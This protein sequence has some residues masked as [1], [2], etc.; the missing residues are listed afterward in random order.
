MLC[1]W[2]CCVLRGVTSH[3]MAPARLVAGSASALTSRQPP[4]L[5]VLT[6][7]LVLAR[8]ELRY[9]L[10]FQMKYRIVQVPDSNGLSNAA[11]GNPSRHRHH[12]GGPYKPCHLMCVVLHA[13][14]R[15]TDLRTK[16][17]Q[18]REI[19]HIQ[20]KPRTLRICSRHTC[21]L[22]FA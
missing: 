12:P 18:W 15:V 5:R 2:L 19:W 1:L 14:S 7:L 22:A 4:D 11:L 6:G 3:P 16:H 8:A 17:L 21:T 10:R 20:S 13:H 9:H